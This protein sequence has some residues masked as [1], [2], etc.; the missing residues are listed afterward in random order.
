MFGIY[1]FDCLSFPIVTLPDLTIQLNVLWNMEEAFSWISISFQD[2]E[3]LNTS[4]NDDSSPADY[5]YS[6]RVE[7]IRLKSRLEQ[8]SFCIEYIRS[9]QK[10]LAK[11]HTHVPTYTTLCPFSSQP[12]PHHDIL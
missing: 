5:E 9:F 10:V 2:D 1:I 4:V 3:N 6:L 12:H 7:N 8:A 11:W